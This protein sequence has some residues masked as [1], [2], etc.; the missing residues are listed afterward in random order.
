MREGA[1]N[2]LASDLGLDCPLQT[3]HAILDPRPQRSL[4]AGFALAV[5]LVHGASSFTV[6]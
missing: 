3:R 4:A 5:R 6:R 1:Q 2:W